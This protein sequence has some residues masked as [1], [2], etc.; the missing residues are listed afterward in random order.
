MATGHYVRRIDGPDGPELHR[1]ADGQRDQSW[2]L[3]A[4]TRAQL[5]RSLFPLG[6][7]PDKAAVRAEAARLGLE[8]AAKPDSQDI[9][10][11]PSGRYDAVVGQLRPDALLP[12]EIVT[13]DGSVVGR[14]DG[15]GR[16]T[17]GQAKRVGVPG[18]VVVALD[19]ATRRI[20]VGPRTT[21]RRDVV[22]R[23]VNWLIEPPPSLR[24]TVKLRARD[25]M[26]AAEVR[27]DGQV[28]LDEPALAAPGQACVFY[29]GERVLGGGFIVPAG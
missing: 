22:L 28:L 12:G 27:P 17:V 15:V 25:S 8:V 1:A 6:G 21:G 26:H 10:F 18:Q 14:H 9:C 13:T 4:T 19:A 2:F 7:M 5:A 29:E 24:C 20:V 23:D 16:F 11:V 3:F